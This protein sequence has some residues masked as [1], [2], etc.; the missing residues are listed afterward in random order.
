MG[1]KFFEEYVANFRTLN[2]LRKKTIS[3]IRYSIVSYRGKH[4][5]TNDKLVVINTGGLDSTR[6]KKKHR[7]HQLGAFGFQ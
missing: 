5:T 2:P 7:Q 1:F 3:S 6:K 4:M